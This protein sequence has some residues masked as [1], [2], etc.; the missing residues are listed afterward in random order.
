MVKNQSHLV[1][2]LLGGICAAGQAPLYL[3]PLSLITLILFFKNLT[4]ASLA[5]FRPFTKSW[6]FGFG[7]F[8][9]TMHWIVE[10]FLVEIASYGWLAPFA[11]VAMA[12]GLSFFWALGAYIGYLIFNTVLGLALGIGISEIARGFVLTGLP[13]G[14]IG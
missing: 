5:G 12:G 1:L 8:L 11:L 10:P 2:P 6:L 7:Y 14:L 13:W 9:V 3:W 4:Q